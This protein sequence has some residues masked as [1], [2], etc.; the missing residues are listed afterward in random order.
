MAKSKERELVHWFKV[1]VASDMSAPVSTADAR[2][3]LEGVAGVTDVEFLRTSTRL[4]K[5]D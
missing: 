1:A 5:K 3:E 4:V 2:A